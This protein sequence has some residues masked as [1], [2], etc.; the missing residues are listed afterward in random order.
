ME[1]QDLFLNIPGFFFLIPGNQ[2]GETGLEAFLIAIQ[3]QT[4]LTS[5]SSKPRGLMRLSLG[6]SLPFF[7]V[8]GYLD[9][10]FFFVSRA[11]YMS[12]PKAS[13]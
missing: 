4:E 9:T 8:F 11:L 1:E 12:I 10:S 2:I 7:D 3:R 6:V 13:L 5:G